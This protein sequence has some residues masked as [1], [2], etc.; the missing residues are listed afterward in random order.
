MPVSFERIPANIRVP[1]FY[2]EVSA[3]EAA[4]FQLLQPSLL[5]GP[6][7]EDGAGVPHQPVLVTDA[8]QAFGL[9][10]A[11]SVLADMVATYRRN[12]VVGTLWCIPHRDPTGATAA[13]LTDEIEGTATAAGVAA[14][15]LGG[16]RYAVTVAMGD[17]GPTIARKVADAI[18]V[19]PFALVTA[20][21]PEADDDNDSPG[22]SGTVSYT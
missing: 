7:L 16:D 11:G 8:Q 17:T 21:A 18:N 5:F 6:M 10:G 20:E 1:L 14:V 15:Y 19:D 4:Y 9:F 13:E 3:R 22:T 12:D 2:A